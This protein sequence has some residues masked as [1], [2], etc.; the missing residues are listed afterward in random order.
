MGLTTKDKKIIRLLEL[1][2]KLPFKDQP[3]MLV[4][5][6]D[7]VLVKDKKH[8]LLESFKPDY[9]LTT[10][11]FDR[12]EILDVFSKIEFI[13]NEI[14]T[15]VILSAG[16]SGFLGD[17]LNSIDLFTKIRLLNDWS[18]INNQLFG[19]LVEL[20][21]VRNGFAHNWTIRNV[22][23][24]NVNLDNKVGFNKFKKDLNSAW[25]KLVSIYETHQFDL[26]EMLR[27]LELKV[28]N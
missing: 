14:I 25:K 21:K 6:D 19:M 4:L 28:K 5:G 22:N 24:R 9:V 3:N 18:I 1:I 2:D 8:F 20:K 11:G 27:D 16:S 26:N 13:V 7:F 17:L 10:V 15:R 12:G 23:Y